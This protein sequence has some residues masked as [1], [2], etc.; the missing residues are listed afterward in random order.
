MTL[1]SNITDTK[2]YFAPTSLFFLPH[3]LWFW[4]EKK[5]NLIL[6]IGGGR[7]VD[8]QAGREKP[9]VLSPSVSDGQRCLYLTTR[10][11]LC[12]TFCR[13]C[14]S[15]YQTEKGFCALRGDFKVLAPAW[16]SS[17][18]QVGTPYKAHFKG[19]QER[20]HSGSMIPSPLIHVCFNILFSYASLPTLGSLMAATLSCT[21]HFCTLSI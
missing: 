3:Q 4:R 1:E 14:H 21:R 20:K 13:T 18:R 5:K 10:L 8:V 15:N 16:F 17:R 9:S 12:V 6:I 11:R 19:L 7:E 2:D